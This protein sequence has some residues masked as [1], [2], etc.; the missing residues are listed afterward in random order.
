MLPVLTSLLFSGPMPLKRVTFSGRLFRD[1]EDERSFRS[2]FFRGSCL[3]GI[4]IA[5]ALAVAILVFVTFS[6]YII[7]PVEYGF[8]CNDTNISNP[9][10]PNTIST[11]HLLIMTLAV[12]FG[13]IF[14]MEALLFREAE[15]KNKTGKFFVSVTTRYLEYVIAYTAMTLM[16]DFMKCGVGRLRPHFLDVC[17]PDWSR[18]NCSTGD[19]AVYIEEAHCTAT[20]RKVRTARTSF[21][22]GHTTAAVFATMFIYYY[23]TGIVRAYCSSVWLNRARNFFLGFFVVWSFVCAITRVT[24]YWHYPTDVLGGA[25]FGA[26]GVLIPFSRINVDNVL[27]SR[28]ISIKLAK[29][30]E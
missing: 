19:D 5:I 30:A 14:V 13:I 27:S 17:Q 26:L 9:L 18:I 23:T 22:S 6:G 8:Y 29:Y 24:D 15:T 20:A 25:I 3:M 11:T 12:P 16:L 2:T 1:E 21:P 10:K 4:D 28:M 7:R